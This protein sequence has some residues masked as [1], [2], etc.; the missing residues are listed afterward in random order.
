MY[1]EGRCDILGLQAAMHLETQSALFDQLCFDAGGSMMSSHSLP[2]K[3]N[4]LFTHCL[5]LA[6]GLNV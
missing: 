3:P 4:S 1:T 6:T 5:E 2:G